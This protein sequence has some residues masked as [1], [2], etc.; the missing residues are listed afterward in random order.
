MTDFG[1]PPMSSGVGGSIHFMAFRASG[2]RTPSSWITGV[3]GPGS[4]AR[5]P[6]E[7][8]HVPTGRRFTAWVAEILADHD[9]ASRAGRA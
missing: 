3:V 4:K 8:L 5:G 2:S 7:F 9:R 6:N 1:R